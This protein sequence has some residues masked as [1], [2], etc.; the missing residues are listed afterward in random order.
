M[1]AFLI[2]AHDQPDHLAEL[3]K[4]VVSP[5]SAAFVHIDRKS[6]ISK[7][8]DAERAGAVFIKERVRVYWGGWS[9][10]AATLALI[11]ATLADPRKFTHFALISG[12]DFPLA[13]PEAILSYVRR[14]GKEHINMVPMPNAALNKPLTRLS[15]RHLE[16]GKRQ[17]GIRAQ[18]VRFANF[19]LARLP[20]RKFARALQGMKPHA[21]SQWWLL[22]R[23]AV[24]AALEATN[25]R[26]V[27]RL[28][29]TSLI[30][31]ESFFQTIVA[32]RVPPDRIGRAFTYT[33]WSVPN[34]PAIIDERHVWKV[35]RPN[36][37]LDDL[38][39]RSPCFF[40]RKFPPDR[41]D[42]RQALMRFAWE[43]DTALET[44]PER[45]SLELE[46]V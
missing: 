12:V 44:I 33:D 14:S 40:V 41:A 43:R 15:V 42:L 36:F 5:S 18:L 2:L 31:D 8:R 24:E 16:G 37:E 22:S 20:E 35:T 21:G 6:D 19:V 17:K 23:S 7:F 32:A 11:R 4:A 13:R 30:P 1:L 29:K 9:Q 38:Y 26:Q 45:A 39:G 3:I 25:D 46:S 34:P 27:L 10:V 28:F